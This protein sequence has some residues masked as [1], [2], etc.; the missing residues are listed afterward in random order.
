MSSSEQKQS[1]TERHLQDFIL[2]KVITEDFIPGK[3]HSTKSLHPDQSLSFGCAS[4]H[5]ESKAIRDAWK[6]NF[7]V[8]ILS[9][10]DFDALRAR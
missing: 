7:P 6:F 1:A 10:S 2:D 8:T 3:A 5:P 9:A 4:G